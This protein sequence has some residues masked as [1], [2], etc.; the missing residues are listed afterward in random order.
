MKLILF[1]LFIF[2][3]CQIDTKPAQAQINVGLRRLDMFMFDKDKYWGRSSPVSFDLTSYPSNT[4][5]TSFQAIATTKVIGLQIRLSVTPSYQQQALTDN[6]DVAIAAILVREQDTSFPPAVMFDFC[7]FVASPNPVPPSNKDFYQG[8]SQN[9]IHLWYKTVT[10]TT[11]WNI[12]END[13]LDYP[14]P[15]EMQAGDTIVLV[16]SAFPTKQYQTCPTTPTNKSKEQ[17]RKERIEA[18]LKRPLRQGP[19]CSGQ[20]NCVAHVAGFMSFLVESEVNSLMHVQDFTKIY[21]AAIS[22]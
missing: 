11:F 10:N 21:R 6:Y 13:F 7:N 19:Y 4:Y 20:S 18:E 16:G 3:L 22:S 8:T 2:T 5:I 15:I 14:L 1:A 12:K 9:V 17:K